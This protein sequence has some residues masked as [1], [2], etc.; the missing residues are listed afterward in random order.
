MIEV[1]A[2]LLALPICQYIFVFQKYC[3][4]LWCAVAHVLTAGL[5][6][7]FLALGV[8]VLHQVSVEASR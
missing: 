4:H 5:L 7:A 2:A 6:A 1:A 3:T 8:T